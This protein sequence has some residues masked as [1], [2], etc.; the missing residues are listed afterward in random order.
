MLEI[1]Q[2]VDVVVEHRDR[3]L[4]TT[5]SEDE[6]QRLTPCRSFAGGHDR[7]IGDAS[8]SV[9]ATENQLAK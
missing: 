9:R 4:S 8:G 7:A 2:H 6:P 3:D 5:E 1:L